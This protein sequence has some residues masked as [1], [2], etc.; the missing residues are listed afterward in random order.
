MHP[1]WH[2]VQFVFLNR[3][4]SSRNEIAKFKNQSTISQSQIER[5]T[6]LTGALKNAQTKEALMQAVNEH[7]KIMENILQRPTVKEDLFNDFNGA[8]KSLGAW[9]GDFIM[10]VPATANDDY[11]SKKGFPVSFSFEELR[12]TDH[13]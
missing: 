4:Q 13:L 5:I 7:E 1:V 11:F 8:I 12:I 6:E 3:K 10:A 9:G 2:E